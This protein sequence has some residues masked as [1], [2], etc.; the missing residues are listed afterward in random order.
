MH[1]ANI[2]APQRTTFDAAR[3]TPL[4]K[5]NLGAGEPISDEKN[6]PQL[7]TTVVGVEERGHV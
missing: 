7:S 4:D 1:D 2:C 5:A 6:N 3:T